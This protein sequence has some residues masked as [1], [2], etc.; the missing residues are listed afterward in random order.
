ML[1]SFLSVPTCRHHRIIAGLGNACHRCRTPFI[2]GPRPSV[3]TAFP[4][5]PT[6]IYATHDAAI[7]TG[8]P[9]PEASA[10]RTPRPP[11][12]RFR[13]GGREIPGLPPQR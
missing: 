1:R 6:A 5:T 9:M 11:Q 12:R 13:L 7:V 10:L 8:N 2:A 4:P 3:R